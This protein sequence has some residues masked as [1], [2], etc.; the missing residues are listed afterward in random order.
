[1]SVMYVMSDDEYFDSDFEEK[2]VCPPTRILVVGRNSDWKNTPTKYTPTMYTILA[3]FV[4]G[5]LFMLFKN[6]DEQ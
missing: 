5:G 4:V 3:V 6:S 2:E 1:M